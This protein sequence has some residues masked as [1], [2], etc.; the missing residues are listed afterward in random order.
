[1][2]VKVSHQRCFIFCWF[3]AS[4]NWFKTLSW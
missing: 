1:M 4:F 3:F 2:A